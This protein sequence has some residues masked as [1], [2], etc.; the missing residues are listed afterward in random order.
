MNTNV[1]FVVGVMGSV[2]GITLMYMISTR[3]SN[4]IIQKFKCEKSLNSFYELIENY[5]IKIIGILFIIPI[6]PDAIISIG[7]SLMKIKLSWFVIIAIISKII[8]IGMI[9]YAKQIG[10]IVSMGRWQIILIELFI[11]NIISCLFK[12]CNRSKGKAR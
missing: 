11:V 6:F 10:Q 7:A 9:V 4:W 8:S 1:S 3:A 5:E 12:L 2:I